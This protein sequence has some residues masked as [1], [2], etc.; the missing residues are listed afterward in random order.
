MEPGTVNTLIPVIGAVIAFVSGLVAWYLNQRSKRIEERKERQWKCIEKTSRMWN[1]L[2]SLTT[3]VSYFDKDANKGAR[4]EDILQKLKKFI[5]P[6]E[7][8][9]SMWYFRFPK[10]KEEHI[11]FFLVPINVLFRSTLTVAY[12]IRDNDNG[13]ISELQDCL[14]V[15]QGGIKDIAH[16]SIISIL[17]YSMGVNLGRAIEAKKEL[18]SNL[19]VLKERAELFEREE[20][21]HNKIFPSI[22]GDEVE[23]FREAYKEF[24]VRKR[25]HPDK[26]LNEFEEF[27]NFRDLFYKIPHQKLCRANKIPYSTNY[28]RHLADWLAFESTCQ[29]P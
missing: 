19:K 16:H 1:Q 21:E 10:L 28:V 27:S 7:D 8:I 22:E 15:I 12:F 5:S 23:V 29:D 26:E 25:E 11:G 2:F 13:E 17:K 24:M 4:I 9:V 3:E 18:K 6:A 20:R 14:E